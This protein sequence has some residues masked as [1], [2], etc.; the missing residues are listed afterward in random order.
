MT[1][2]DSIGKLLLRPIED[3]YL[4]DKLSPPSDFIL[5][6]AAEALRVAG[7]RNWIP[8]IVT[9]EKGYKYKIIANH[10][11]YYA[12][13]R[14]GLDQVWCLVIP[15][16]PKSIEQVKILSGQEVPT[17]NLTTAS[18]EAIESALAHLKIQ[19]GSPLSTLDVIKAAV[20]IAEADKTTWKNLNPISTLKCGIT[21]G[22]KLDALEQVFYVTPIELP[23]PP[24]PPEK[25]SIKKASYEGIL[26]RLHYLADNKV[27]GFDQLD[28]AKT[29]EVIFTAQKGKWKSLSPLSKL[30]CGFTTVQVTKLRQVFTL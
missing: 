12:V 10:F 28:I 2:F 1:P 4:E 29:A 11:V 14:A 3:V 13:N 22:K 19:P 8:L 30:E 6:G 18:R 26:E 27:S 7:E 17:L 21:K 15:S 20:R 16:D 25:V 9:E 5:A 24:P 23:P